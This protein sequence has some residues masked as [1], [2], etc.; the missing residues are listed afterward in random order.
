[1]PIH[2]L[3]NALRRSRVHCSDRRFV[4]CSYLRLLCAFSSSGPINSAVRAPQS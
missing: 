4:P 1:M 3:Q 2:V